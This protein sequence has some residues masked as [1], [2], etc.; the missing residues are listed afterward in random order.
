MILV[1]RCYNNNYYGKIKSCM[2]SQPSLTP[3]LSLLNSTHPINFVLLPPLALQLSLYVLMK[4]KKKKKNW[5][6]G[7]PLLSACTK[8]SNYCI[9]ILCQS[10]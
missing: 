4:S 6:Q 8:L 1:A 5:E 7:T 2:H 3:R 10:V 9:I